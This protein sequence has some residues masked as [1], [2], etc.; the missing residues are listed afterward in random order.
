M[1]FLPGYYQS[2]ADQGGGS[3]M[4][5]SSLASARYWERALSV[6]SVICVLLFTGCASV[7]GTAENHRV[8]ANL[9]TRHV[10]QGQEETENQAVEPDPG[11]DWFY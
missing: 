5:N 11:Y 9:V 8:A 3:S 2:P 10:E 4:K 1:P 7:D 6:A